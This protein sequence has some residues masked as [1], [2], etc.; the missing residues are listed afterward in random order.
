[1]NTIWGGMDFSE[2]A[3]LAR[4]RAIFD[5]P[6]HKAAREKRFAREREVE[7]R[8]DAL[9]PAQHPFEYDPKKPSLHP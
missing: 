9:W 5:D 1:M 7:A 2:E 8:M 3:S 4:L 6:K